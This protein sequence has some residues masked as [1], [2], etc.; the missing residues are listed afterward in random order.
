MNASNSE[1]QSKGTTVICSYFSTSSAYF[2]NGKEKDYESGFHYYGSRYYSSEISMWLS[3]D[4]RADKYPSLSPYNYCANNPIKLID[5][6]GE[7]LEPVYSSNGEFKGTTK[8]GFTGTI[9]IYDGNEDFSKMSAEKF[10]MVEGQEILE[11]SY[12]RMSPEAIAKIW[13]DV[14]SRMNGYDI[15][16]KIFSLSEINDILYDPNK[17]ESRSA[18]WVTT[19][20]NKT[21]FGGNKSNSY[22]H[23]VENLQMSIIVHEWY[24]HIIEGV[25]D[26]NKNHSKAF[27]NV[28]NYVEQN[29]IHVTEDYLRFNKTQLSNYKKK[30]DRQ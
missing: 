13:T 2:F 21:I 25:S 29:N 28:L 27:E 9:Y 3:T 22:L 15:F 5:P 30:E 24:S 8:E 7:E 11:R 20:P 14:V 1:I 17:V 10:N 16:G 23:T 4:P 12:N 18:N 6:N 19:M 26:R